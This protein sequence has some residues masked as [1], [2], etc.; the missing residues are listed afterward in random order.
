MEHLF[1]AEVMKPLRLHGDCRLEL[2]KQQVDDG[3]YDLRSKPGQHAGG[4][5]THVAEIRLFLR[6]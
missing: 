2:L 3:S 4:I 5:G 6:V 1:A